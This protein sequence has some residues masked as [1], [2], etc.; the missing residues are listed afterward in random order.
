MS[1]IIDLQATREILQELARVVKFTRQTL[2]AMIHEEEQLGRLPAR[3]PPG[4]LSDALEH[5]GDVREG[6]ILSQRTSP[7]VVFHQM[8]TLVQHVLISWDWLHALNLSLTPGEYI[9][10]LG[11]QL[12][13]YNHALVALAML[14]RLPAEAI[15]F[16]Q[17][18]PTYSDV[19]VPVLPDEM[20]AR[21]EEIERMIYQANIKS[22]HSL[23]YAPF[24]RTYAFFEASNWLVNN[25]L[26]PLLET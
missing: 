17:H 13:V 10:T 7:Q 1:G 23:D 20:L 26:S 18:R 12:V 8:R 6:F 16:P 22:V 21:I 25:H 24:R 4:R 19:T 9:E 2:A 3:Q 5:L 11:P 14:P 15:T